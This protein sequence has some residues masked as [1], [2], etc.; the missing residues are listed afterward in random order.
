MASM[1]KKDKI[2]LE[3][4]TDINILLMIEKGIRREI[5]HAMHRYVEANNKCMKNY[6]KNKKSSYL[7][8]L[9]A[10]NLYGWTMSWKLPVEGFKW[11]INAC[12]FGQYSNKGYIIDV[13][14]DNPKD[15]HDLHSDLPFFPERMKIN[16]CNK[17]VC[18]LYVKKSCSHVVHIRALKQA[19]DHGVDLRKCT[20]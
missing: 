20:E 11:E 3:L 5:C 8:Y 14:I 15:L 1:F 13:T 17:V 2:I 10:N 19:L 12:R 6:D 4:L 9:D 18:N 7:M 16:K